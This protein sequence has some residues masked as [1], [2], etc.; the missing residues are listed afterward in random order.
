MVRERGEAVELWAEANHHPNMAFVSRIIA[1]K[2]ML[3]LVSDILLCG[4]GLLAIMGAV[5]ERAGSAAAVA[6]GLVT[7]SGLLFTGYELSPTRVRAYGLIFTTEAL[8]QAV[9]GNPDAAADAAHS[10]TIIHPRA[11]SDRSL[12][13]AN[14]VAARIVSEVDNADFDSAW[15]DEV[16][17]AD[18]IDKNHNAGSLW[19]LLLTG[20]VGEGTHAMLIQD[21]KTAEARLSAVTMDTAEDKSGR[22]RLRLQ[23]RMAFAYLMRDPANSGRLLRRA[24]D[25]AHGQ[26]SEVESK[27]IR[28]YLKLASDRGLNISPSDVAV[29]RSRM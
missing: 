15:S 2:T 23:L 8:R 22:E 18:I 9:A 10:A 5:S 24:I 26:G 27:L 19:P 20:N 14:L 12:E 16:D 28:T 13:R 21:G 11:E 29:L 6:A 17:L 25:A 3:S 7:I 1:P 4:L